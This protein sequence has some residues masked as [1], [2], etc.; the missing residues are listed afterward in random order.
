VINSSLISAVQGHYG[1]YH[2]SEKSKGSRMWISPL[3][4]LYWFFVLAAVARQNY[5]L[6]QLRG[7]Y[8]F[9]DTLQRVMEHTRNLPRRAPARIPL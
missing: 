2:L 6:P 7:T 5:F 4:T 9:R 8:T 1:D 3:M